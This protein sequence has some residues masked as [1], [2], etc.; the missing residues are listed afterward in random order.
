MIKH[1]LQTTPVKPPSPEIVWHLELDQGKVR[2]IGDDGTREQKVI[3]IYETGCSYRH[4]NATLDGLKVDS[5]GKIKEYNT[6][7]EAHS[8]KEDF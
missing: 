5:K 4:Y 6:P 1:K 7:R 8:R 3:T 2:V